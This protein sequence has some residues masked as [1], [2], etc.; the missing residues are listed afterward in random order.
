MARAK[1]THV[2]IHRFELQ[3]K[4]RQYLETY[5]AGQT[6]QNVVIPAAIV[7]GVGT[8]G[9]LGYKALKA[10]YEWGDDAIDDIKREYTETVAKAKAVAPV[11]VNKVEAT[12]GPL[13]NFIKVGKFLFS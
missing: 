4:E 11:T 6:V 9:Y 5:I 7:A 3:E 13:G 2:V 10:A 1:P 12:P 8:A